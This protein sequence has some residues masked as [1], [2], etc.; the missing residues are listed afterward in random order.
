MSQRTALYAEH[1]RLGGRMVDFHGW[2]LPVQ[3]EGILAEH[4]HCR[5]AAA[6]FDTSHMG[7]LRVRARPSALAQVT[8]QDAAALAIG[9]CQYGFLLNEAGGILDDTILIRLGAEDFLL[10]VNAA[11]A[12]RDL[13]WLRTRLPEAEVT[14]QAPEGGWGKL[15]LQGPKSAQVLAPLADVELG[16]LGYFSVTRARVCGNDC[17]LTRAGYTGELGYE[18]MAPSESIAAIFGE[19]VA[20]PAVKPAG[21]GARDSLRLEMGYPLYGEDMDA[22]TSP[23]EA[24]LG[25]FI[26]FG[27]DFVGS[28]ALQAAGAPS[29]RRV[30]FVA[31]SRQRAC[32]GNE[33]AHGGRTVGRVTTAA[34]A[35]SLDVS[36]GQ[37]YVPA[38]LATPGT[39]LTIRTPRRDLAAVVAQPPLYKHGTCRTK[40]L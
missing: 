33:I 31:A 21:L 38:D 23:F 27:H 25:S 9:R 5:E 14:L 29:K 26:R 18:L 30:A 17:V 1:L 19:L 16:S 3:Y 12:A 35:P 11:P 36:I 34:F 8:T 37:G 28:A 20:H 13:A 24:S 6:V 40:E 7:Q 22:G 39:E 4:R 32:A 10:V 2:E 15:D